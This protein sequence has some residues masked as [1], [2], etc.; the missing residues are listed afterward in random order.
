MAPA[1]Q[2]N[3]RT[4]AISPTKATATMGRTQI[5]VT[6][7]QT[8]STSVAKPP[9]SSPSAMS[10]SALAATATWIKAKL[11]AR[12]TGFDERRNW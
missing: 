10:G 9:P 2:E 11:A 1:Y 3:A 6:A 7:I 4:L 12:V 8:K 5:I